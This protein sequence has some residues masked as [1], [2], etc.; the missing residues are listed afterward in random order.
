MAKNIK[1]INQKHDN[2]DRKVLDVFL[3]CEVNPF[4]MYSSS[5]LKLYSIV[6]F[7]MRVLMW[8]QDCGKEVALSFN[9]L[10]FTIR[11]SIL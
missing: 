7:V 2:Q 10:P 6:S 1:I 3:S 4:E 9:G 8:F 11:P 5:I